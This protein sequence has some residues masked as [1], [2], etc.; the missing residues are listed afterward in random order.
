[1]EGMGQGFCCLTTHF[2]YTAILL[3]D[4]GGI[5][6]TRGEVPQCVTGKQ[7]LWD[8]ILPVSTDWGLDLRGL[9]FL[10]VSCSFTAVKCCY[11]F[12]GII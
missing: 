8:L 9:G 7:K 6:Q 5:K 10:Q 4:N 2:D 1:M 3:G 11:P 12:A